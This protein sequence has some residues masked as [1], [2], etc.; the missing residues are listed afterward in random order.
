MP[1]W[2]ILVDSGMHGTEPFATAILLATFGTLLAASVLFSQA[3]ERA[4]VPVALVFLGIGMLAGSEG[5]GKIAFEDYGFAFRLGAAA[6][7]LI[8]FD[9]GLN[10][11]LGE[12]KRYA[13]PAVATTPTVASI[14]AGATT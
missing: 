1:L 2:S 9:G 6:L 11:P 7:T 13:S 10:T 3:S 5:I 4:R 12:L 8:L 14:A